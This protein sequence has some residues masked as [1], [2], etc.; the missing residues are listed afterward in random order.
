MF[1]VSENASKLIG[2]ALKLAK[3]EAEVVVFGETEKFSKF[4]E[5]VVE[6]K[7]ER[8]FKPEENVDEMDTAIIFF[9][10]GTT[11]LP[12]GICLTHFAILVLGLK[13][14]FRRSEVLFLV[15]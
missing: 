8:D 6:K 14:R 15:L 12:K 9:S 11:G 7:G 3:L 5:F 1:F 10:S 2:D 4:S 13:S